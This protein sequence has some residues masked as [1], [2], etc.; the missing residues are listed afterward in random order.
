MG[1]KRFNTLT[2]LA[3]LGGVLMAVTI[4]IALFSA[5]RASAEPATNTGDEHLEG[6]PFSVISNNN[7]P[8]R[9]C[10]QKYRDHRN[11]SR[12]RKS[13]S[14]SFNPVRQ[15][16]LYDLLYGSSPKHHDV[17]AEDIRQVLR[18]KNN[19]LAPGL[20]K[21]LSQGGVIP[22]C[23][24]K[25]MILLPEDVNDYLGFSKRSDLRI[26][27]LG[28]NVLLFNSDSGFIHDILRNML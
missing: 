2:H 10:V 17:I 28:G 14:L 16:L 11:R 7:A 22:A 4:W 23:L 6:K 12:E 27:V 15:N 21:Q 13:D 26:G 1:S 5:T 3:F 20:Q 25:R 8:R 9:S 19:S 18:R 24:Q